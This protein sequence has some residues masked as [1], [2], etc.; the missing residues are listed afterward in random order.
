M[1][2]NGINPYKSKGFV[3]NFAGTDFSNEY[4]YGDEQWFR[5]G[6]KNPFPVPLSQIKITN[7]KGDV[8]GFDGKNFYKKGKDGKEKNLPQST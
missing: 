5:D 8:S 7:A 3:P 6:G 1:S 2:Q 4:G